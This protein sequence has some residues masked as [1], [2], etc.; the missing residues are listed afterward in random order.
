MFEKE[1][2]DQTFNARAKFQTA[3]NVLR[4]KERAEWC[5]P[6]VDQLSGKYRKLYKLR[7]KADGTQ[8][9]PL[10]F[11]GPGPGEFTLLT[12]A[13]EKDRKWNPP[14]IRDTALERMRL[15]TEDPEKAHELDF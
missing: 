6:D 9:R 8:H 7:F 12:W 13:T 2:H 15:I 11:I 14:E 3:I 4:D 10:G 1:Y 5:R